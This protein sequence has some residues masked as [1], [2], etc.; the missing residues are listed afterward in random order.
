[1]FKYRI[2]LENEAKRLSECNTHNL[3]GILEGLSIAYALTGDESNIIND[4]YCQ[5][6]EKGV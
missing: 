5:A 4:L 2:K 6:I 1:M 3:S